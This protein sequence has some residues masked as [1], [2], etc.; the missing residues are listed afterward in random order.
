VGPQVLGNL[1][2]GVADQGGE[3]HQA[4][5]GQAEDEQRGCA[6]GADEDGQRGEDEHSVKPAGHLQDVPRR[7]SMRVSECGQRLHFC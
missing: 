2:G 7:G 1:P 3:G 6:K 5:A 4:D